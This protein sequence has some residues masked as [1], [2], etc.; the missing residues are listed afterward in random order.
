MSEHD[1]AVAVLKRAWGDL[2]AADPMVRHDAWTFWQDAAA[3]QFWT[4][5]L[6]L[7]DGRLQRYA[8]ALPPTGLADRVPCQLCLW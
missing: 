3:L 8:T 7:P 5:L 4:D 6:G 2:S 1:L